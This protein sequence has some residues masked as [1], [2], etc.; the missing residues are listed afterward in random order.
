MAPWILAMEADV[1]QQEVEETW[2][3]LVQPGERVVGQPARQDGTAAQITA[4]EADVLPEDDDNSMQRHTQTE[5]ASVKRVD[6]RA[7]DEE[8]TTCTL[9]QRQKIIPSHVL[10]W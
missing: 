2:Q 10:Y 6:L 5:E 8:E 7:Q 3:T 1:C 4:M 9:L